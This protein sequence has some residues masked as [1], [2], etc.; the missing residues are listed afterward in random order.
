MKSR[1]SVAIRPRAMTPGRGLVP[2]LRR[3]ALVTVAF[4]GSAVALLAIE[5]QIARSH[6]FVRTPP[7]G[8]AAGVFGEPGGVPL[9]LVVL[10]DS[11]AAGVGAG[12]RS[13]S[14]PFL[15]SQRLAAE[16]GYRVELRVH[17]VSG[18]RAADVAGTQ[19]ER[20]LDDR[21]DVV[22]VV[23][24][25]NDV[26]HLTSLASV[27]RD[28]RAAVRRLR[29]SG[30]RV[31][32]GGVPDMR[33][34]LFLEPLRSVAGWRGRVVSRS[35]RRVATEE[36]V[37]YV[38]LRERTGHFFVEDPHGHFSADAFHPG[39]LGYRRWAEAIYPEVAAAAG[40]AT[41]VRTATDR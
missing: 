5:A 23:V 4:A 30:A 1:T 22:L 20:A 15:I 6:D 13:A 9:R 24:G 10:G 37:G 8:D 36:G 26:T 25:G 18:A 11:A 32:V 3:A 16:H 12:S 19:V 33:A 29:D 28:M 31:V 21:P 27:R 35:I 7:D 39:P 40:A 17:G 41:R 38:P 2:T 34:H 14:Y